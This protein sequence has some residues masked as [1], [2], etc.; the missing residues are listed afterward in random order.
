MSADYFGVDVPFAR[1]CGIVPISHEP[2]HTRLGLDLA[3][4]HANNH[5]TA[6]GG[7]LLT[8]LD[9]SLG[10]AARTFIGTP[11]VTINMQ[12]S[13]LSPGKGKLIGEG[14]V[15]KPGRTI[16]FCE[17]EIRDDKGELIAKASGVFKAAK[18]QKRD[19]PEETKASKGSDE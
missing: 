5:G 10:S 6:H 18:P 7:A 1:Y 8:L 16:I 12:V 4:F 13:F 9:I 2:G 17:G 19:Q 15:V 11:V 3:D 14:R